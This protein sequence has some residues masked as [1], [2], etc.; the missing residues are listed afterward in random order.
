MS[1]R[2]GTSST[3]RG[4][5]S[6]RRRRT[7]RTSSTRCSTPAAAPATS[8]TWSSSAT[9][10]T[11]R[12][13]WVMGPTNEV[14]RQFVGKA[15]LL[16]FE[17]LDYWNQSYNRRAVENEV[18]KLDAAGQARARRAAVQGGRRAGVEGAGGQGLTPMAISAGRR[19]ITVPG[20]IAADP[21]L[22]RYWVRPGGAT[23]VT[24]DAD[25]QLTVRD[26]DGGQVAEV[27]ALAPDGSDDAAALG[28]RAD[29]PASVLRSLIGSEADGAPEVIGTLAGRGPEPL[30]RDGRP[31]LRGVVARRLLAD[32]HRRAAA[33]GGD[34]GARGR[35]RAGG[36]RPWRR[37]SMSR[38]DGRA[39]GPT[40]SSSC[41]PR[42]PSRAW[43]SAS[44]APRPCP[45]R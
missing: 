24:L 44:T 29:A 41:L 10:A 36:R 27:T 42:S 9:C 43:T 45:T 32:V 7:P 33:R 26:P 14:L 40:T 38:S 28:A 34:R 16:G 11:R 5:S 25:D 12:P 18:K 2:A 19:S 13:G 30:G 22:E 39:L 20:L 1:S 17:S 31:A 15:V 6:S 35:V 37:T 8:A 3:G 21:F 23:V 4:R